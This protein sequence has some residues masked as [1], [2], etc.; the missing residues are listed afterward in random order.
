[1]SYSSESLK[2]V[3]VG[4]STADTPWVVAGRPRSL[5]L[6]GKLALW[7]NVV[8][9][10][11]DLLATSVRRDL[12]ARFRGTLLGMLWVLLQPLMQFAIYAFIFTELLGLRLGAAADAPLGTM[13]VYMFSGTLVWT[14]FADTLQRSTSC[15][16]ENRNLVQKV[17]F[18]AQLLPLQIALS[19][20]V[21]F[22][23]GLLAFCVFTAF[24]P[25]WS[26]PSVSLIWWGPLLLVLQLL[27][28][29][30]LGLLLSASQVLFR[31]TQ[32]VMAMVLT[33]WMFVTPIFWVPSAELLPGI[34][35]WLPLVDINPVH[36][37]V[38]L[39]RELL[40]S[41]EPAIIF[42][43]SFQ[44]SLAMLATWA[45]GLF[46]VGTMFFFRVERHLSDEV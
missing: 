4:V 18:D 20:L 25:T 14:A 37:L 44:H 1:M 46:L 22:G 33:V 19:S 32:P 21:T 34:E 12:Q 45:V 38:Y 15:I 43:G 40:M 23:A 9:Q 26:F 39:W 17:R 31:D 42:N 29:L 35:E 13:G 41:S 3:S 6:L 11:R 2:S 8:W 5:E 7:P 24:S 28:T 16:L 30:G 36:H 27:L 10:H